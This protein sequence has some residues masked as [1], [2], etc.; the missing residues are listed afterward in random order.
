MGLCDP[1]PHLLVKP[2]LFL[3]GW[4][5]QHLFKISFSE[6][7]SIYLSPVIVI[8]YSDK[9]LGIFLYSRSLDCLLA[10][11]VNHTPSKPDLSIIHHRTASYGEL[12]TGCSL[13][14][15]DQPIHLPSFCRFFL[16]IDYRWLNQI[17]VK[18][19]Y[20]LLLLPSALEHLCLAKIFTKLNLHSAYNLVIICHWEE[21]DTAFRTTSGNLRFCVMLYE[22]LLSPFSAPVSY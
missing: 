4:E 16:C 13:A 18:Y 20:P 21:W 3:L 9:T 11:L 12:Y 10:D 7:F 5:G 15:I 14:G 19:P 17:S 1:V 22:L 8:Q 2:K 6:L